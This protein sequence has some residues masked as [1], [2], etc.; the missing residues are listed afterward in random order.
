MKQIKK[1]LKY[2]CF[3]CAKSIRGKTKNKSTCPDCKGTGF[4]NDEVYYTIITTKEG[5][6][7]CVD[8]DNPA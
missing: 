5:K 3:C 8:S 4:F 1:V 6:Q 7:I 2:P